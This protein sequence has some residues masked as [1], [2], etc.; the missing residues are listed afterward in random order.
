M[1][2]R[3][4][5]RVPFGK[6]YD[7]RDAFIERQFRGRVLIRGRELPERTSGQAR[8]TWYIGPQY[9][10]DTALTD[11]YV[12]IN[13]VVVHSGRHIHQGGLCLFILE[14]EGYTIVDGE[15]E[16]W[17]AGDLVL[18]PVK[19][20]GVEHQHFNAKEGAGCR[21]LAFIYLP[22]F[23]HVAS[24][25]KQTAYS[26]DYEDASAGAPPERVTLYNPARDFVG[27]PTDSYGEAPP[28][29]DFHGYF[30][31]A[32]RRD[33][34]RAWL[35][36]SKNVVRG[37]VLPWEL[38]PQGWMQWYLHPALPEPS[39][40][41][42]LFYRQEI[43]PGSRS[44]RQRHQGGVIVY[45]L[46]GHGH[47]LMDGERYDWEPGDLLQLPLRPDG[48]SYQHFNDSA[49]ER[50]RLIAC[51]PNL[52]EALGLDRGAGFMQLENCPEWET[53]TALQLATPTGGSRRATAGTV[54]AD[55]PRRGQ[56]AHRRG[57]GPGHRRAQSG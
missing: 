36:H 52:I 44:G 47:T 4:R 24:G 19:P 21:W 20:G 15:K 46:E 11:W 40:R 39:I 7:D 35:A 29:G 53:A 26:A 34:G 51:E 54:Q 10:T 28:P 9:Y 2:E 42:Y 31:L 23:D 56:E 25:L 12:F 50:V 45:F 27:W 18:L 14:G 43:P 48:V 37:E 33:A 22:F 13:N 30:D 55:R 38:N 41:T 1:I 57:E 3:E 32:R 17:R 49:S 16:E 8:T 6:A 5:E